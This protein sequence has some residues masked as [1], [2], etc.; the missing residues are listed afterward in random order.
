MSLKLNTASGGSITL[1]EADTAS[2]L[3]ITVP[4]ITGTALIAQTAL[5]VPNTTGTVMVS[6]NMPAFSAYKLGS[7]VTGFTSGTATK[8]LLDGE[9]FDTASCFDNTTNYRF[10]PNVAGYYQINAQI[11]SN[12]LTTQ[13]TYFKASIYKNGSEYLRSQNV[14]ATT[15]DTRT[16]SGIIYFNG[17]T[18]YV[19]LYAFSSGGSNPAYNQGSFATSMSGVL[20]RAA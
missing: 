3:T 11:D 10:T 16:V 2:N 14:T 15:Y 20:V 18:D 12:W 8:V 7:S 6:G 5:T 17:S 19:E 13:F 9:L 4:A 1:Q